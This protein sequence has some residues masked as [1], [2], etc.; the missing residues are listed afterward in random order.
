MLNL[1][2]PADGL[3]DHLAVV[4]EINLSAPVSPRK[5]ITITKT[6]KICMTSFR[7]DI[8]DSTL[9]LSFKEAHVTPL[10]K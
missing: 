10:L 6:T 7:A 8:L 5:T 1:F 2:F 4:S 9:P 3:S